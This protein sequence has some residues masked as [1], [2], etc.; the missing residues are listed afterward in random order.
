M[1]PARTRADER[2]ELVLAAGRA[3]QKTES[4]NGGLNRRSA[5][6]STGMARRSHVWTAQPWEDSCPRSL[7]KTNHATIPREFTYRDSAI[8]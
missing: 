1:V 3:A 2:L 6:R 7:Q 4:P 5:E 8:V